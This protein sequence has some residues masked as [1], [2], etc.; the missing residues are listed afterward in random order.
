MSGWGSKKPS[1]GTAR[2]SSKYVQG[3]RERTS[4]PA[5]VREL[6]EL[7]GTESEEYL[8][9]MSPNEFVE[10]VQQFS[11]LVEQIRILQLTQGKTSNKKTASELRQLRIEA[12][13][14]ANKLKKVKQFKNWGIKTGHHSSASATSEDDNDRKIIRR[15]VQEF[16]NMVAELK[17]LIETA[18]DIAMQNKNKNKSEEVAIEIM[19]QNDDDDDQMRDAQSYMNAKQAK[20]VEQKERLTG[21]LVDWQSST[22]K[23][24]HMIAKESY[25]KAVEMVILIYHIL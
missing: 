16:D 13:A 7:Q 2:S 11:R 3:R 8:K 22:V 17:D 19:D 6:E 14:E 1:S 23:V 5:I 15:A 10:R 21:Q 9:N 18:R 24:E 12:N 4:Q 25:E 20:E